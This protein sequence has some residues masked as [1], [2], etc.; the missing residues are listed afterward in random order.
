MLV[1]LV[2]WLF[3]TMWATG[4]IGMKLGAPYAEP[5]TFLSLRFLGVLAVLVPVMLVIG[6]PRLTRVETLRAILSERG[7][8]ASIS[9][10]CCGRS[11]T[12]WRRAWRR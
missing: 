10:Q 12:V 4:Y 6:V 3:V 7:F 8:T 1:R 9:A 5:F 2:P 11:N